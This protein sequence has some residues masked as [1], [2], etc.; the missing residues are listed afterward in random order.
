MVNISEPDQHPQEQSLLFRLPREL[1]DEIY[2]HCTYEPEG[3]HHVYQESGPGE[4]L[5]SNREPIDL[6]LKATCKKIAQELESIALT[7]NA[8]HSY[9]NDS[10]SDYL[11]S[12]RALRFQRLDE[13]INV[14]KWRMLFL[15]AT[16][17]LNDA[18]LQEVEQEF[19]GHH[20]AAACQLGLDEFLHPPRLLRFKDWYYIHGKHSVNLKRPL[21]RCLT[22]ASAHPRFDNLIK[23]ACT[24][25]QLSQDFCDEGATFRAGTHM[26]VLNWDMEPWTTPTDTDLICMESLLVHPEDTK[27]FLEDRRLP[28]IN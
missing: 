21:Q 3:Y 16:E 23:T 25:Q 27:D 15:C 4:L 9:P 19:S 22:L 26:Q 12:S 10:H 14:T 28:W 6:S 20:F 5:K 18:M 13:Y 7:T 8:V 24:E 1:R 11:I 2:A 17:C